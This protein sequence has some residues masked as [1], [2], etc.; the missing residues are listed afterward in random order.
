M[1]LVFVLDDDQDDIY[2]MQKFLAE[3]EYKVAVEYI[4]DAN[5]L[6]QLLEKGVIPAMILL[7]Y[8]FGPE[9]GMEIL[10]QLKNHQQYCAVPVT[11]ISNSSQQNMITQSYK[12]GACSFI[13]KPATVEEARN[14]V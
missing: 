5:E 6:F 7:D 12:N 3:V 14:K 9:K 1:K 10:K 11:V 2:I 13:Q 4:T 8:N